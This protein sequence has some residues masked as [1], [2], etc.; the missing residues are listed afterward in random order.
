MNARSCAVLGLCFAITPSLLADFTYQETTKITGGAV[1]SMMKMAA[2]FS[3]QAKKIGEPTTFTVYLKGNRMA[4]VSQDSTEIIDLDAESIT[5]IN[6]VDHTYTVMTFEQ[7]RQQLEAARKEA[8]KRMAE[9]KGKQATSTE[10]PPDLKFKVNVRETGAKK[11]VSGVNASEAI[12]A[13]QMEATDQKSGQTG[14]M[15]ITNDMWM[16]QEI[17]GYDEL[18][19]FQKRYAIK[20]GHILSGAFN[21]SMLAMQPGMGQ[22]L[23]DMVKEMSKLKG[24]PVQQVMRIGTTANGEPLPAASEAPLPPTPEGP[25]AGDV[26]KGAATSSATSEAASHMGVMGAALGVGGF[27]GFGKKKKP[28]DTPPADQSAAAAQPTSAVL[29]E[30][31]TEMGGF[32]SGSVDGAH[33][34]VPSGFKQIPIKQLAGQ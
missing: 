18:R 26:A 34:E 30:S 24:V 1:V 5:Q 9:Q 11:D 25:S 33:F 27:G 28:A 22:G 31:N 19:E 7:M 6:N 3:K 20:M 17:P 15:A 12:L 29:I 23:A 21:P 32:S 2:M 16:A 13:M 10:P 4:R 8:E 14:A